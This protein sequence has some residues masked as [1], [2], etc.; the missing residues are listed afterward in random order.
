MRFEYCAIR[1]TNEG[2]GIGAVMLSLADHAA[3]GWRLLPFVLPNGY[4]LLE[5]PALDGNGNALP[6][7][8][9]PRR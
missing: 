1:L 5:R 6:C 9:G 8:G 7:L 3:N 4:G 2:D